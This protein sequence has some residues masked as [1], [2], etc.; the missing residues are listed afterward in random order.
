MNNLIIL[1]ALKNGLFI[2]NIN[3]RHDN[4]RFEEETIPYG[5][6]YYRLLKDIIPILSPFIMN[7]LVYPKK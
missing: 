7:T 4:A 5:S 3:S 2:I 1:I 6:G